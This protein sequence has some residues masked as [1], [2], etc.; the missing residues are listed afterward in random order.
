[1]PDTEKRIL[2]QVDP[3]QSLI[4]EASSSKETN[5][6]PKPESESDS[7]SNNRIDDI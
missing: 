6:K 2:E 1:M 7:E 3:K 5:F 4:L